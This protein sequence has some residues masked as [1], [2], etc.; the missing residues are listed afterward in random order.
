MPVSMHWPREVDSLAVWMLQRS[1]KGRMTPWSHRPSRMDSIA[2]WTLWPIRQLRLSEV[3]TR[4]V[5]PQI[6]TSRPIRRS[7][8]EIFAVWT[9]HPIRRSAME[10]LALR[11]RAPMAQRPLLST[12][13]R[14]ALLTLRSTVE[15]KARWTPPS[16]VD[17]IALPTPSNQSKVERILRRTPRRARPPPLRW[18]ARRK[19]S[20]NIDRRAV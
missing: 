5:R 9:P 20:P 13:E 1:G 19:L 4:C 6:S 16:T 7:A 11:T 17:P 18:N 3:E 12:V 14:I 10:W 2:K 15:V 8:V